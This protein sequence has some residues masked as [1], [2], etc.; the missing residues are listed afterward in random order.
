MRSGPD[1]A[2]NGGN[3]R[4]PSRVR[5][6]DD[7][8]LGEQRRRRCGGGAI[9][10]SGEGAATDAE[11]DLGSPLYSARIGVDDALAEVRH[12]QLGHRCGRFRRCHRRQPAGLGRQR[13]RLEDAPR[14][15]DRV[16][17]RRSA[18]S[19]GRAS[20]IEAMTVNG[21]ATARRVL[22]RLLCPTSPCRARSRNREV[23]A[24]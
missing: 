6:E 11:G 1:Q 21:R 20:K 2:A 16:P 8:D 12:A 23:Q 5:G 13:F 15:E 14:D 3:R 9:G 7:G 22:P 24:G 17:G 4:R 19:P 18:I 10:P